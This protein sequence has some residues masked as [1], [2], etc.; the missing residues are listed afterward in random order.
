MFVLLQS[1]SAICTK[2]RL[3]LFISIETMFWPQ[4]VLAQ[5]SDQHSVEAIVAA[6]NAEIPQE[7]IDQARELDDQLMMQGEF[8]GQRVYLVTDERS[9]GS[10]ALVERLLVSMGEDPSHWVVRVFETDEPVLN[11]FVTGGKYVYLFHGLLEQMASE[12]EL[13][14][15]LAHELGHSLLKQSIRQQNDDSAFLIG[16]A[17]LG[18]MLSKNNVGGMQNLARYLQSSYSQLDEE[19]ADALAVA[20]SRRAG[21]NPLRGVDF[22]SRMKRQKDQAWND[23]QLELSQQLQSVQQEQANCQQ[24]TDYFNGAWENQ[25]Q[26]NADQTN[27]ICSGAEAL[28]QQYNHNVAQFNQNI[29]YQQQ[30]FF[31]K[32][33]IQDQSHI[34]TIAAL[35]NYLA[36]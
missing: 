20:I 34:A 14:F 9:V 18:T 32:F 29:A 4:L 35:T 27:A 25:T 28:R 31:F 15:V 11:A 5:Y 12:D 2:L 21:F 19:E 33:H 23:Y 26:E 16:L 3:V 17:Q 13:A 22:F 6:L 36:G 1:L 30:E 24:W 10:N 8:E 7:L